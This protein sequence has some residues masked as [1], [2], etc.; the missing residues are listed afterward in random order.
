MVYDMYSDGILWS[1]EP[2]HIVY[3]WWNWINTYLGKF[4]HDLTVL[5]NPGIMVNK[6]KHPQMAQDF[7]LVKYY[8]LPRQVTCDVTDGWE[9]GHPQ[10]ADNSCFQG[11]DYYNSARYNGITI[12]EP[13]ITIL[14][15]M[16][17]L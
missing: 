14:T 15:V 7:R 12:E 6:G 16:H 8:N 2:K 4:H 3:Q 10:P 9:S 17:R 13:D 5:P 1:E 11:S